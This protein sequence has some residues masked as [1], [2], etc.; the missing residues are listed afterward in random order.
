MVQKFTIREMTDLLNEPESVAERRKDLNALIK[1]MKKIPMK[2]K[3]K[4]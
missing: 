4:N 3:I 2:I 1:V